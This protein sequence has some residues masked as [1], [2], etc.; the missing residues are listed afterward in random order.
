MPPDA[1]PAALRRNAPVDTHEDA[2]RTRR[3]RLRRQQADVLRQLG[4]IPSVQ[5]LLKFLVVPG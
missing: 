3:Q 2:Q 5:T 4:F 1:V